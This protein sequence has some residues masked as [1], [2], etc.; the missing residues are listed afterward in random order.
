ADPPQRLNRSRDDGLAVHLL[1]EELVE[2][3]P[4]PVPCNQPATGDF[5]HRLAELAGFESETDAMGLAQPGVKMGHHVEQHF[6]TVADQQRAGHHSSSS[7]ALTSI[8]G[9]IAMAC[10]TARRS[11]SCASRK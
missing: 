2:E 11:G 10:A 1:A 3:R 6:V 5:G 4:D 7:R 8:S 9:L